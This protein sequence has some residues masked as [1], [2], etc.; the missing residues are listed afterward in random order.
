V[1]WQSHDGQYLL[2][3]HVEA[4]AGKLA[5]LDA[6]APVPVVTAAAL[7]EQAIALQESRPDEARAV[8]R[9]AI[10]A[11]PTAVAAYTNL[12]RL[13]HERR[14]LSDAEST[15]REGLARCGRDETL[16]FNLA[17][18]LEYLKR[19]RAAAAM[20]RA[21]LD[22][23]PDLPEAHYNL[24]LLCEADG[25]QQEGIR[26]LSAYRKLNGRNML[27]VSPPG[28]PPQLSSMSMRMRSPAA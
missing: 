19:P 10:D 28:R 8:Y 21:A 23:N 2:R 6:P 25:L 4:P 14:S 17:L 15:Y 11:N 26:H 3:F 24:A 9:Q 27:S 12:G 1:Q 13:L 5:F 22:E 20:Y 16:F 7:L 18:L